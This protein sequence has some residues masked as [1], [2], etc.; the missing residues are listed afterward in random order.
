M[1]DVSIATTASGLS[2][3]FH[4]L[5]VLGICLATIVFAYSV[6]ALFF[7][8]KQSKSQPLFVAVS[9][10]GNQRRH[11]HNHSQRHHQPRA[12]PTLAGE[13]DFVPTMPIPVHLSTDDV[14]ADP[15]VA[16][17][18]PGAEI[19]SQDWD[20]DA[21]EIPNPPPAYGRWRSSVRANPDLLH[22]QS[23][24]SPVS[25][26]TPALPS[27]TYE[28]AMAAAQNESPPSYMT[29]ESPARQREMR[30]ARAGIARSQIVEPE[31]VEAR[32]AGVGFAI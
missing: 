25:P 1:L 31:M 17:P 21:E 6:I 24:P 2:T 15:I 8:G 9:R 22:W 29:R 18:T 12:M 16:Q 26:D 13:N 19:T 4:I 14:R 11:R 23:V 3:A 32:G 5:F 28:E 20:K 30:E 7:V 27:P 10:H